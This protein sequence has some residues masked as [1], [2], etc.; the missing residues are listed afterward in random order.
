MKDILTTIILG[1]ALII[2]LVF[3]APMINENK[4][5][6]QVQVEIMDEKMYKAMQDT[7]DINKE[8]VTSK[9]I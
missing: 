9:K 6:V 8:T 4:R 7:Q 2:T 5:Q 3:A 1:V